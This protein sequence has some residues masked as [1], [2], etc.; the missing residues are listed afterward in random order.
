MGSFLFYPQ[1]RADCFLSADSRSLFFIRRFRRFSQIMAS[2]LAAARPFTPPVFFA[3]WGRFS[4]IVFVSCE[5]AKFFYPQIS[6][7]LADYGVVS[8]RCAAIHAAGFFRRLGQILQI[9]FVSCEVAKFFLS[10][11]FADSRRLWRRV[12]PLR[13][14]SRRR[15]FSQI[16]ADSHRLWRRVLPLRGH[17]RRRFFSQ[18]GADSHR[19]WRRVLPLRGHSRRR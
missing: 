10:A 18:I 13:G 12:L 6:Q 3:D 14:H 7:I 16:G 15:F 11:D 2:C 19:L 9:V 17:S 8:C 4:Q 5:V 1:T